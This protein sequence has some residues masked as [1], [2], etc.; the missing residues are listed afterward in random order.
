MMK[1]ALA[2][3]VLFSALHGLA[4]SGYK[5]KLTPEKLEKSIEQN[6]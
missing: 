1:R 5:V 4:A 6:G 3:S 2:F